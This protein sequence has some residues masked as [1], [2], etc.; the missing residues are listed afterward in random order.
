MAVD[1]ELS[2]PTAVAR[3]AA[4]ATPHQPASDSEAPLSK[5]RGCHCDCLQL[6]R[7]AATLLV[8]GLLTVHLYWS[9]QLC[10]FMPARFEAEWIA[11]WHLTAPD[12]VELTAISIEGEPGGAFLH[13]FVNG[14]FVSADGERRACVTD[15][16]QDTGKPNGVWDPPSVYMPLIPRTTGA[17]PGLTGWYDDEA[18]THCPWAVQPPNKEKDNANMGCILLTVLGSMGMVI[19]LV[20]YIG[21]MV[22]SRQG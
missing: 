3:D 6:C 11:R 21:F 1:L 22:A 15:F 2:A 8:L 13:V 5:W 7:A 10:R 12:S 18:P 16:T 20:G 9:A 14:S 4:G 17:L 19:G